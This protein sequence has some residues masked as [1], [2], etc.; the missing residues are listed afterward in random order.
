MEERLRRERAL[1]DAV[2]LADSSRAWKGEG[3]AVAGAVQAAATRSN[4][5]GR[6]ATPP[7]PTLRSAQTPEVGAKRPTGGTGDA[8]GL[9]ALPGKGM[10]TPPA[11]KPGLGSH[12]LTPGSTTSNAASGRASPASDAAD[13][14]LE[15]LLSHAEAACRSPAGV[16]DLLADAALV[17][18]VLQQLAAPAGGAA[19]VG[20]WLAAPATARLLH[21]AGH[22]M[23]V[24]EGRPEAA[25]LQRALLDAAAAASAASP[26]QLDALAAA[27]DALRCAEAGIARARVGYP[28]VALDATFKLY[29]DCLIVRPAT[30]SWR[31][32]AAACGAAGDALARAQRCLHAGVRGPV[33]KQ[34]EE[35]VG[36]AAKGQLAAA[37]VAALEATRT[38]GSNPGEPRST[39][40]ARSS[41][42]DVAQRRATCC[43]CCLQAWRLSSIFMSSASPCSNFLLHFLFLRCAGSAQTA[44]AVLQALSSAVHVPADGLATPTLEHFPLAQALNSKVPTNHALPVATAA[45]SDGVTHVGWNTSMAADAAQLPS[46]PG[47]TDCHQ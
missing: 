19:A 29:A 26:P 47:T 20:A 9:H 18:S 11:S 31:L 13:A 16:A 32:A 6:S 17:N 37:L 23:G 43:A 27:L 5:P 45:H 7:T 25:A 3:G 33:L 21:V 1:A 8:A 40:F 14:A 42:V 24:A 35:T 39:A 22:L 38:H 30:A 10:G 41:D 44:A 34:A 12:P 4:T 2:V 36:A 28:F 46:C 15:R